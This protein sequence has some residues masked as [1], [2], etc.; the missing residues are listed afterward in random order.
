MAPMA[1]PSLLHRSL[2]ALLVLAGTTHCASEAPIESS[3][4]AED[5][6]ASLPDEDS[7]LPG[8]ALSIEVTENETTFVDLGAARVA[9]GA[10][11]E[12]ADW[13]LAFRGWEVFTNSGP[14]GPGAGS[15]FGP[16]DELDFL[17][18]TAP[19]V[20]FMREDRS[21]GAFLDWYDYDG[22][23]HQVW[24]RYH[25]YG[26]RSGGALFKVQ[27]LGYYGE[28]FGA[29][30]SAIYRLRY[31]EVTADG[32][33]PVEDI[34]DIDGTAGYPDV[35]D[36]AESTCIALGRGELLKLT[37][38]AAL[39]SSDWDLCFRRDTISVNGEIG[40]PGGVAAVNLDAASILL[41]LIDDVK[42]RTPESEMERF[43]AVDFE[44]LS[45][46]GLNYRG[47]R[48][49]SVFGDRWFDGEGE[50]ST[51]T[52]GAWLVQGADGEHQY[53]VVFREIEGTER[54]A[55]KIE[56]RIRSVEPR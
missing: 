47:D 48:V 24:S 8:E 27:I 51:P 53:L 14:S 5:E 55:G 17:F 39:A 37:P 31:A 56:M 36:A 34:A 3:R 35:S 22:A 38:A 33:G 11:T 49:V 10:T 21:G 29:P 45:D 30:V 9:E 4:E 23:N 25:V 46:P 1:S 28:Q 41:E 20:P 54:A 7:D 18:E 19:E 32:T 50:S 15:G 6:P 40:G 44:R 52:D 42:E 12:T 13:D 16:T 2:G 26:I 43:E